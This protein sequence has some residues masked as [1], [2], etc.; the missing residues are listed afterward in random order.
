MYI[1]STTTKNVR[2]IIGRGRSEGASKQSLLY[3]SLELGK[4]VAGK[5]L[6]AVDVVEGDGGPG[7]V[8]KLTLK[9][10][11]PSRKEKQTTMGIKEAFLIFHPT[12]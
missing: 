7:T 11:I 4:L 9:P 8:L 6:E 5:I 2:I 12:T 3:G 10:E 1:P